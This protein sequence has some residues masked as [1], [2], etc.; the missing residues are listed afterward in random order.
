ME[1]TYEQLK[2][3]MEIIDEFIEKAYEGLIIIDKNG[4]ITKFKYEKFLDVKEEDVIGK[5]VTEVM[6]NTRLHIVLKTGHP[7]IGDIQTIKGHNVITSRIPIIRDG[8]VVGAVGTILFKDVS[9]VK[10]MV[11]HLD[12][13]KVHIKKY[14]Q[15]LKRL[16]QAKYSFEHILTNDPQMLM[17]IGIAKKAAETNSSV[18]I[19]GRSGTGKEYFAHAIHEASYRRYGPFVK[20]NCAG[21]PKDLFESELF[22]YEPGAFTGASSHGKIGKFEIAN[23]GTIFL[24]EL[25]SLPFEM[26]AKLLRVIE[27]RELERIG[28]NERIP[29]DVR[30]ISASNEE[31]KTMVEEGKFRSDLYY[32]LN[33]V[34]LSLPPLME[35]KRDVPML[36]NHFLKRF[37]IDY[38]NCPTQFSREAL[39]CLEQYQWP[40][41]IRELRNVI[42]SAVSLTNAKTIIASSLPEYISK[43]R[44][45]TKPSGDFNALQLPLEGDLKDMMQALEKQIIL[46]ALDKCH[47][48]RTEAALML[49]IHRTALYKKMNKLGIDDTH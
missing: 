34:T 15:D 2:W 26:Q 17:M 25:S 20:I 24:D 9:E 13:M 4:F 46:E 11:E 27:E 41:N 5:H 18:Y 28:G 47:G 30:F 36:A 49:G 23:G 12:Q 16:N 42:E 19:E 8:V 6:E 39:H 35:R 43:F 40:G 14:K 45:E 33:V 1:K 44:P 3:E 29:L 32:R 10:H 37:S 22:G 31:L 38:P 21:I 48:N 7:E